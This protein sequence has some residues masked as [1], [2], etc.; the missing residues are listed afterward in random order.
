MRSA[1]REVF[2]FGITY[3]GR[4]LLILIAGCRPMF[5]D[6]LSVKYA[7]YINYI[8][9]PIRLLM[10]SHKYDISITYTCA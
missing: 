6:K 10:V 3:S 9:R 1:S 5:I 2:F 8:S 4:L 7:Q